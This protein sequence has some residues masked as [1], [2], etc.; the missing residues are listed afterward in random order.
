MR[1]GFNAWKNQ[2][3]PIT[4]DKQFTPEQQRAGAIAETVFK[5]NPNHPGAAHYIIHAYDH[6]TLAPKALAAARTR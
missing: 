2:G 4:E 1:G 5:R 6:G 3:M